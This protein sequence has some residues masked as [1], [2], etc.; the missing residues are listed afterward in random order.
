M[1]RLTFIILV[2]C[3][4]C[5]SDDSPSNGDAGVDAADNPALQMFTCNAG[6]VSFPPLDKS[7]TTP[8]DCIVAVHQTDCCGNADAVGIN[9]S[10]GKSFWD[11]EAECSALFPACGCPTGPLTTEDGL[12]TATGPSQVDVAC[13]DERCV[14]RAVAA[15]AR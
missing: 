5:G 11:L 6:E 14:T 10:A 4:G 12:M 13:V 8:S 15:T 2:G 7:C 9:A 3:L 1:H